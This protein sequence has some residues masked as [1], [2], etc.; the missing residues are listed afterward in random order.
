V[1]LLLVRHGQSLWNEVRRF[2]GSTDVPL[3]DLGRRQA[4]ALG[5][6][7]RRYRLA[8]VYVSPLQRARETAALALGGAG[9]G[10]RG[11]GEPVPVDDL[12]E[13]CLGDWEGCT[14]EE[15]RARDGDPY[16]AWVR[17]PLDRPPPRGEPLPEVQARVREA[18]A[19]IAAAHDPRDDVL[20]VTHGGVISVHACD[21]LGCSLNELWRLR[22]D[23]ASITVV[24]P[25]RLVSLN[26]TRHLANGLAPSHLVRLD[27]GRPDGGG[28][29]DVGLGD[30]PG[31]AAP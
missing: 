26:D 3:S 12:R 25:P 20:V 2:Q 11:N 31:P 8:A 14:V 27:P 10:D 24:R 19:R 7:L 6:A 17:S 28:A 5:P 16:A 23:N 18:L 13:L 22:V 9:A 21:L 30:R 4:R 1:S 29:G 15:I